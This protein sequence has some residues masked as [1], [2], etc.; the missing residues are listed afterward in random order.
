[1]RWLGVSWAWRRG[2]GS[3]MQMFVEVFTQCSCNVRTMFL[4]YAV[5]GDTGHWCKM[6]GANCPEECTPCNVHLADVLAM[7]VRISCNV[8]PM[9]LQCCTNILATG[10]NVENNMIDNNSTLFTTVY[11]YMWR[12]GSME[13]AIEVKKRGCKH[14]AVKSWQCRHR[15]YVNV[16]LMWRQL[17]KQWTQFLPH[18]PAS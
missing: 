1:M 7:F 2:H 8:H 15:M 6:F 9:F 18:R 17:R 12:G 11:S 4:Q 14:M 5:C 16:V 3:P 13:R 10:H